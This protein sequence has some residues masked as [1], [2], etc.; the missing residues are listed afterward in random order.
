M[1]TDLLLLVSFSPIYCLKRIGRCLV[2]PLLQ[3]SFYD[4]GIILWLSC[5]QVL[6]CLF[7]FFS[8]ANPALCQSYYFI[9]SPVKRTKGGGSG[10]S[11]SRSPTICN[12]IFS[13]GIEVHCWISGI[14][15]TPPHLLGSFLSA[16][17][18]FNVLLCYKDIYTTF[19]LEFSVRGNLSSLWTGGMCV[20]SE[21]KS[22]DF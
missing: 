2:S 4:L 5:A 14:Q 15:H 13:A 6:N 21:L 1:S 12:I 22:C 3:A 16:P 8:P 7:A 9:T 17:N 10:W 20:I 18:S 19:P 11:L